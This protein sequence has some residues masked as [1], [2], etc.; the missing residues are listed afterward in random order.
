[1]SDSTVKKH[2]VT[3]ACDS[4]GDF[5]VDTCHISGMFIGLFYKPDGTA[6]LPSTADLTITGKDTG[7]PYYAEGDI[8]TVNRVDIVETEV[9]DETGTAVTGVTDKM[10]VDEALTVTIASGGASDAGELWIYTK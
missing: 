7:F 8:G 1:M 10:P 2:K 3:I 9:V 5:T 6:P 4:S